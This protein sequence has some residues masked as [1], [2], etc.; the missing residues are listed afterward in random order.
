MAVGMD[1]RQLNNDRQCED[2]L[3]RSVAQPTGTES[4]RSDPDRTETLQ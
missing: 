2:P 3:K 4:A 1:A